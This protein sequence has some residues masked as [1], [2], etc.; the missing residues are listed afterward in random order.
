M[1]TERRLSLT[2][3][4]PKDHAVLDGAPRSFEQVLDGRSG[5]VVLDYGCGDAARRAAV[6]RRGSRYVGIDPYSRSADV[7]ASG[8]RLPFRT[9]SVDVVISVAVFEHLLDPR[10]GI[11]EI[12]RVLKPGGVLVGYSA[13]LENFHEVSYHHLTHK[14][15][16]H[17]FERAGLSV[18]RLWPTSYGLD[19][20]IGNLL[21]P[22]GRPRAVKSVVRW[23]VRAM[24]GFTLRLHVAA[25]AVWRRLRGRALEGESRLRLRFLQ[26]KFASG[27]AFEAVRRRDVR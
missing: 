22:G 18:V 23:I 5:L 13:F 16:E 21:V 1:A 15:L 3:V 2:D 27:I 6:V 7:V 11:D 20:Q 24:T 14:A 9:G 8:E 25:H 12:G 4:L 17:L 26:L 10:D 19:Y